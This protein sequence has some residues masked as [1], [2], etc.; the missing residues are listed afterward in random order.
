M[1]A[2]FAVPHTFLAESI[3][4]RRTNAIWPLNFTDSNDVWKYLAWVVT[5]MDLDEFGHCS[6][7]SRPVRNCGCLR[8]ESGFFERIIRI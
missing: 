7:S 1:I 8:K 5:S 3:F 6:F 2:Y 4:L